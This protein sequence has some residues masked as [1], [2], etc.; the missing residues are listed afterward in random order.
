M[1]DF[2]A[3]IAILAG[4][5]ARVAIPILVTAVAVYFLRR[6]DAHW[7]SEGRNLPASV[8]K[9]LC[10]EIMGCSPARRKE[11]P[12]YAS[13]L[14]CWQARRTANG[15]LLDQCLACKVFLKAPAPS[16]G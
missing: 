1:S 9:P 4:V 14:P 8:E 11:C 15:H 10:W 13:V 3:A 16:L 12:G 2:Y 5:A 7:Q 6:L